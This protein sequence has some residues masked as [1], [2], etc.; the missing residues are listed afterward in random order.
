MNKKFL[1]NIICLS[2]ISILGMS[3]IAC[4]KKGESEKSTDKK[5]IVLGTSAD[6][7]PYEFHKIIDGKD[8]VVGFDVEIAKEIAKDLGADLEINE[9]KFDGLLAAI[10]TKKVDMVLAG[11]NP[12]PERSK[13]VDFSNIY[14]TADHSVMVKKEN[15]DKFKD[16]SSF[17]G[18]KV[19]VQKGSIQENLAKEQLEGADLKM[20]GKV[21]ELILDLQNNKVDAI[22]VETPVAKA[23]A[24]KNKDIDIT[25]VTFN[26]NKEEQ[27]SAVAV[28]KGNEELKKSI[29][30]TLD[31][32]IKEGKIDEFVVNANKLVE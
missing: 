26:I 12:T 9:M 21:T 14:Y 8:T 6:Y 25:G 11:M 15:K 24:D 22:V 17:K 20:L 30:K 2:L 29:N 7:P 18:V 27:G 3:M 4:G 28:A 1:K 23:Y 5:K 32:L 31:R 16:K 19:G 13:S 10:S